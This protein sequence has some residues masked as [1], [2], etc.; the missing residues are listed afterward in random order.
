[1][2]HHLSGS[3]TRT[4]VS[5]HHAVVEGE[6][7]HVSAVVDV[8]PSDDRVTMVFHPDPCQSV[9]GDLIVL[10]DS[11]G[12]KNELQSFTAQS[13]K[14]DDMSNQVP[15]GKVVCVTYLCMVSDVKP[16]VLTVAD[17]AVF[18]GGTSALA[19]HTDR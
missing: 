10:V 19:A 16:H 11:L 9:V 14:W 17:V 15:Y 18:D 12:T 7:A 13:W 5:S 6:D 3:Q 4:I 1:M 8:V 2:E